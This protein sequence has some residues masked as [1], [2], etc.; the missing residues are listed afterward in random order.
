MVGELDGKR[1]VGHGGAI[2][3]FAT[4]LDCLPDE[5][6]GVVVVNSRDCANPTSSRM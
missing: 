2:Y 4:Q 6:L 1:R 3:G 5:K